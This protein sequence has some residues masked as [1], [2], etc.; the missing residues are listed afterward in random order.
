MI[1]QHNKRTQRSYRL[2]NEDMRNSLNAESIN[3]I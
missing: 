2:R 3:L 1:L